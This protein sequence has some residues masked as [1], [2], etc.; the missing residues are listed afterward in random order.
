[1]KKKGPIV[2]PFLEGNPINKYMNKRCRPWMDPE[3]GSGGG[4]GG[5]GSDRGS[6]P[7]LKNHINTAFPS[8]I[9]PD[10]LKSHTATKP[11]FNVWRSS[12]C[13]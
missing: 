5:G 2:N 13:Q 1:M 3:G 9:G 10:P 8:N 11:A 12:A 6:R 7:P 4:G